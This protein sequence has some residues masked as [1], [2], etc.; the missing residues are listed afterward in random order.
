MW[1]LLQLF[2]IKNISC[3]LFHFVAAH[4][5]ALGQAFFSKN[6]TSLAVDYW[7]QATLSFDSRG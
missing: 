4:Y 7:Q 2:Q 3:I 1:D 5:G 6:E